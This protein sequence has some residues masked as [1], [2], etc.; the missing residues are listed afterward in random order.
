[1]AI[2]ENHPVLTSADGS[3][4]TAGRLWTQVESDFWV[5]QEDGSFLGSV[6]RQSSRYFARNAQRAYV[7][8]YSTL[9][10]AIR[11]IGDRRS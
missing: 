3:P 11:A 8:E 1:M 7:G 5:G 2:I 6:E 9:A 4:S 10:S